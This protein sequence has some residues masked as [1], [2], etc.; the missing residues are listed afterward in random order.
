M[1]SLFAVADA[2]G[3]H[4]AYAE[5]FHDGTAGH[6][7]LLERAQRPMI[8]A[9]ARSVGTIAVSQDLNLRIIWVG[10]ADV[11]KRTLAR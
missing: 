8:A 1:S 9:A 11:A 10:P 6:R 2:D 7:A 3:R 4:I 5:G